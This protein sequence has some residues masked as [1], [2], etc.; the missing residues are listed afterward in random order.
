MLRTNKHSF[1]ARFMPRDFINHFVVGL[2]IYSALFSLYQLGIRLFYTRYVYHFLFL[3]STLFCACILPHNIPI[4]N[5][6]QVTLNSVC[7]ANR[8]RWMRAVEHQ[9][10]HYLHIHCMQIGKTFEAH[11]LVFNSFESPFMN[12]KLKL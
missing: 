7:Y 11:A 5:N 1:R 6:W 12:A 3:F 10:L 4:N 8:P 2:L 9:L